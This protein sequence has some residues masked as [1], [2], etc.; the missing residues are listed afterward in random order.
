MITVDYTDDGVLVT[1]EAF[2]QTATATASTPAT[3]AYSVAH[4]FLEN[5]QGKYL[6]EA[7]IYMYTDAGRAEAILTMLNTAAADGFTVK[8]CDNVVPTKMY[9]FDSDN[10]PNGFVEYGRNV[11][12]N[13]VWGMI[14]QRYCEAASVVQY[15]ERFMESVRCRRIYIDSIGIEKKSS[16]GDM[17]Y[18]CHKFTFHGYEKCITKITMGITEDHISLMNCDYRKATDKLALQILASLLNRQPNVI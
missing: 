2:G 8:I 12:R 5:L 17:V 16:N 14:P 18:L 7:I 13:I 10:I 11:D 9:L 6:G 15:D 1:F 4:R 3:A